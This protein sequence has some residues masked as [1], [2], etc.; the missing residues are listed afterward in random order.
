MKIEGQE[1]GPKGSAKVSIIIAHFSKDIA[2]N[3]MVQ[4]EVVGVFNYWRAYVAMRGAIEA[5]ASIDGSAEK[6]PGDDS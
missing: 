2:Y 4:P 5:G 1:R 3:G 6:G